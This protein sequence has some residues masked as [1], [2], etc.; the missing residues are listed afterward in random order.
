MEKTNIYGVVL[1][2]GQGTRMGNVEKPKQFMEV[3]GKPIIIHT[4][5]KFV[6][7]PQFEKVIVLSPKQWMT[8]TQDIIKKYI[9]LSDKIDVIEGGETRNDTVMNSIRHIEQ[10]YGLDDDTIIVTHDSVRPFVTHRILE[11]NIRSAQEYGACDTV[12]PATDTIVES[13]N[14]QCITNIPDRSKMYQGQTPQS[15]KAK[16][17]REVF[18]GLNEEEKTIL[19]DACKILVLKGDKVQLVEGEVFNIKITYPYD[20]R[21]AES[22]LGGAAIC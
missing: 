19:T 13:M 7:H 16:R 6:I 1:A 9:S 17:L 4:L 20:L 2:G 22:I 8:Y 18:E 14:N 15:F 3:G 5:E 21:V 10:N 12:I 11:E